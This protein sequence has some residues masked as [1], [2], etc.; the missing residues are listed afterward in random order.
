MTASGLPYFPAMEDGTANV[1]C[2]WCLAVIPRAAAPQH[3][4][5]HVR[6][7][8]TVP[9]GSSERAMRVAEGREAT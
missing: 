6:A 8:E 1:V 9:D 2:P 7:A 4:D 3:G 5:A